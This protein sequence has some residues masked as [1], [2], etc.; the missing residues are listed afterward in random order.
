MVEQAQGAKLPIQALVDRVTLVFVPVI[1]GIAVLTFFAWLAFG[2]APALGLALV[3]AVAVLIIAC[4]CAM[5]LATPTSIMVGTGKAAEIGLLFR[6]GD[7]L[8]SLRDVD[9]IA[10]DKTGTL[11]RGV[12]V[13]TAVL[14]ASGFQEDDL[15]HLVASLEQRSEHPIA[16][17]I[18]A[19][20]K[21]RGITTGEASSFAASAGLGAAADVAGRHVQVGADRYMAQL[22]IDVSGFAAEATRFAEDGGTPVYAAIDGHPAALLVVADPLKNSARA[23]VEALQRLGRRV[24][25][26]TG[27]DRRTAT[28]IGR[29]AGIDEIR[30][31]LLP[32]G[33]VACVAQ[34]QAD[35][36]RVAFVGDG[37]N[38]APA[39]AQA[40]V[41]IAIGTGTDIA[42][43]SAEL[44]L[45]SGDLRNL[46]NAVAL[47]NATLRNIRQN[48]FWAFAYNASLVPVAAGVLFPAFGI[49]LSPMLAA[50][51]MAL[52]SLCVVSNALRLKR[53]RP[54]LIIAPRVPT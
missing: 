27:D 49:L 52:S 1:I 16:A 36:H 20:A 46:P 10:L 47:S 43:D 17:A 18:V 24:V 51:A 4:P 41:G 33:K 38:D 25:M 30:A 11:T 29:E 3:N 28:A 31:E 9:T 32:D 34:M 13:L 26:L 23:A 19:G 2:P 42:I 35:G 15:L 54:P 40:D 6:K 39:L 44:V 22:G 8:Q 5:G 48:L 45:M 50:L 12:P 53:F 14:P 21:A 37:I 7:A